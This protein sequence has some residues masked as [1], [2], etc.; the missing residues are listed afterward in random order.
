M[1]RRARL[2][3]FQLVSSWLCDWYVANLLLELSDGRTEERT[4]E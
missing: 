4:D 3:G 1:S 2:L